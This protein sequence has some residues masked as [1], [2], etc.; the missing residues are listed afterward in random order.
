MTLEQLGK[1]LGYPSCCIKSFRKTIGALG[2]RKGAEAGRG[3]G[4]IP[5]SICAGR[6]LSGEINL[7]DLI[8]NR[9]HNKPFPQ[10]HHNENT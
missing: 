3:T 6:V 1:H 8:T 2:N 7:K 10:F 9:K 4:F 5:C